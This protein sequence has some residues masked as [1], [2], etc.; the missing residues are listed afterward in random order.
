MRGARGAAEPVR[1][2]LVCPAALPSAC[3]C[4]AGERLSR[5][6]SGELTFPKPS[7]KHRRPDPH[8]L[9]PPRRG[10][11]QRDLTAA[12]IES[13]NYAVSEGVYRAVQVR[14]RRGRGRALP[15][16]AA[17]TRCH[18]RMCPRWSSR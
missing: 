2:G 11:T 18:C 12:H 8:R 1:L 9:R 7:L 13:F 16:P 6:L 10:T 15:A 14:G 5:R 4:G 17:L 3:A